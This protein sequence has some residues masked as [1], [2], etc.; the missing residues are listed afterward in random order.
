MKQKHYDVESYRK[1]SHYLPPIQHYN[2]R[3]CQNVKN[4]MVYYP[5]QT[6]TSEMES[7]ENMSSR[8][9]DILP[10]L[11]IASFF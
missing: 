4:A 10:R 8:R 7:R 6:S 9:N 11:F 1:G 2:K 3:E 5:G